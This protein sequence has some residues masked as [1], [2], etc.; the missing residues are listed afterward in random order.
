MPEWPF[1]VRR[2]EACS[3]QADHEKKDGTTFSRLHYFKRGKLA[4]LSQ[5]KKERMTLLRYKDVHWFL[6]KAWIKR[7]YVKKKRPC[8]LLSSLLYNPVLLTRT[9]QIY[10]RRVEFHFAKNC[11][12]LSFVSLSCSTPYFRSA[13]VL[14][15][16]WFHFSFCSL[17]LS[18]SRS[19][20][21]FVVFQICFLL[22]FLYYSFNL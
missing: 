19:R 5:N 21:F 13:T 12:N 6:I 15:L 10:A 11:L 1:C 18:L 16:N 14:F 22:F 8:S 3:Q 7:G 20:F 2:Y 4:L 9:I 17:S